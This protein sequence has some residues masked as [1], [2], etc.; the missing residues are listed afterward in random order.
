MTL[1][2][3]HDMLEALVAAAAAADDSD[4]RLAVILADPAAGR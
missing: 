4:R 3:R 2:E 1:A